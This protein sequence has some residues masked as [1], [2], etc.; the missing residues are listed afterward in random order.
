MKRLLERV[1]SI[2]KITSEVTDMTDPHR[3]TLADGARLCQI[4]HNLRRGEA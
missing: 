3:R 1:R 4:E 2:L